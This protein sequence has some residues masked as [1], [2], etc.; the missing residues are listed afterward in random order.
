MGAL[1]TVVKGS[2]SALSVGDF[3]WISGQSFTIVTLSNCQIGFGTVDFGVTSLTLV[4]V[5]KWSYGYTWDVTFTNQIG[6]RDLLTGV[7]STALEPNTTYLIQVTAFN[8]KGPGPTGFAVQ[9][10]VTTIDLPVVPQILL[11]PLQVSPR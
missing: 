8:A 5:Y 1:V 4:T 11:S 10:S 3:I 6:G 9:G 2:Y 7:E